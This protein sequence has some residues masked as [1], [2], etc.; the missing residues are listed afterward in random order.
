MLALLL[1]Q[2][3]RGVTVY[4]TLFYLPSFTSGVRPDDPVEEALQPRIR[5]RSIPPSARFSA[6]C[7]SKRTR[8]TGCNPTQNLAAL[9]LGRVGFDSSKFGLWRAR[10]LIIMGIWIAIGG[11]NMLLYL[12]ALTNVPQDLLRSRGDRRRGNWKKFWNVTWPQL[13]PTTFFH[14]R[15]ELH[16]RPA[17]RV[18]DRPRHDRRAARPARR[19]RSPTY[20]YIKAF[21][22]FQMG[23]ASAIAWM[24]FAIIFVVTMLNWKFGSRAMND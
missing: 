15:D 2:K 16:R 5:P 6:R 13:A 21:E 3:L 24:L 9:A 1:S 12:A 10:R 4:R 19:P 20:I 17:G 7:T 8:Q 18:R 14:R 22:E 11:A 23:Y